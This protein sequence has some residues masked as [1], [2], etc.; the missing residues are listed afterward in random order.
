MRITEM[1]LA[2]TTVYTCSYCELKQLLLG[3]PSST[4]QYTSLKKLLASVYS[5]LSTSCY[6]LTQLQKTSNSLQYPCKG[7]HIHCNP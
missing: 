7:A 1:N 4:E 3:A 2:N 6:Q 5:T